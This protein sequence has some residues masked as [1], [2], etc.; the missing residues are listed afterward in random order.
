MRPITRSPYPVAIH[1]REATL[2]ETTLPDNGPAAVPK[3][4]YDGSP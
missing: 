4:P 2:G 3:G 1:K